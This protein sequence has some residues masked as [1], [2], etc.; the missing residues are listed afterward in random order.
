M[1]LREYRQ[2]TMCH[3]SFMLIRLMQIRIT[4]F[5]QSRYEISFTPVQALLLSL[6]WT[7]HQGHL[8]ARRAQHIEM[9]TDVLD[10]E[11]RWIATY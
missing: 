5:C 7:D 6:H 4:T 3:H 1:M 8:F 11:R 2:E 10:I 9:A